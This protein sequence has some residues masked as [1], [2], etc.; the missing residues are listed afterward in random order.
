MI[1]IFKGGDLPVNKGNAK[2]GRMGKRNWK[3]K[4]E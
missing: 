1:K 2:R 4:E 3:Q